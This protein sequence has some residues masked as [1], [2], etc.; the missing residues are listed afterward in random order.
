M[1]I[2]LTADEFDEIQ[3]LSLFG[4]EKKL[5]SFL[6]SKFGCVPG[7]HYEMKVWHNDEIIPACLR[8]GDLHEILN[9]YAAEKQV[10]ISD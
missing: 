7:T 3:A 8:F 10:I 4:N 6:V 1:I 9:I 5:E 2:N